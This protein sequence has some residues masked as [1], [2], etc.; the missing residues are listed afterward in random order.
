[1]KRFG[2]NLFQGFSV[3]PYD[4]LASL[5][6]SYSSGSFFKL[7]MYKQLSE[8]DI[9]ILDSSGLFKESGRFADSF[10]KV[11]CDD[12]FVLFVFRHLLKRE[13]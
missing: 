3:N 8:M 11:F 1:M 9:L 4:A 2:F 6:V 12:Q 13:K 10:D 7:T 5:V